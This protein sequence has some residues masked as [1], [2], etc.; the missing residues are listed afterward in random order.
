MSTKEGD[1]SRATY[2]LRT[3]LS[4]PG[5]G[6]LSV[7]RLAG[8][9]ALGEE[10]AE[11]PNFVSIG[12]ST[13]LSPRPSGRAFSGRGTR[14]WWSAAASWRSSNSSNNYEQQ[15]KVPNLALAKDIDRHAGRRAS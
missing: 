4:R 11:L 15:L 10:T 1:H 12:P 6:R 7:A 8:G 5:A 2:L 13:F 3:G 14:R 9:Q